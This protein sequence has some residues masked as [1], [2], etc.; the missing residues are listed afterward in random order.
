MPGDKS[1]QPFPTKLLGVIF[2]YL[3]AL[4]HT[5]GIQLTVWFR[6]VFSANELSV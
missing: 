1:H 2:V 6:E 5:A 3:G 4:D